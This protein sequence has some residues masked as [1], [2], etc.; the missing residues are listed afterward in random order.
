MR[1][2]TAQNTDPYGGL[3]NPGR[4]KLCGLE[5]VPSVDRSETTCWMAAGSCKG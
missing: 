4:S 1:A 3:S 5:I 2:W